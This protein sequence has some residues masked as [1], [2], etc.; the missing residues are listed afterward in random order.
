MAAVLQMAG[1]GV[2]LNG[3]QQQAATDRTREWLG[4]EQIRV[5]VTTE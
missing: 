3:R 1:T 2:S 5:A 4:Q